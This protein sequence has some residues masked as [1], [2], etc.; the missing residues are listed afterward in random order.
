MCLELK[1]LDIKNMFHS[2][3]F[4]LYLGDNFR[5]IA[6]NLQENG[7]QTVT[8]FSRGI[9]YSEMPGTGYKG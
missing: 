6:V 2:L 7:D 9:F 4:H 8:A 5:V 1:W 3:K